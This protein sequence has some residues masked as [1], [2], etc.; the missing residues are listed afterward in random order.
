MLRKPIGCI[1]IAVLAMGA[2]PAPAAELTVEKQVAK[3]KHGRKIKVELNSGER[4][5]GRMGAVSADQFTLEPGSTAQ[6]TARTIRFG[7]ARSV[8]PDGMTTGEKWAI[9]GGVWI[10]AG[11]AGYSINH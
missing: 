7:E 1:L 5:K 9:F 2:T 11:I 6:G 4:L 3:L 8:S 10:A